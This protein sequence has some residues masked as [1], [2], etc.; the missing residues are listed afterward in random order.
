M[1]QRT[2]DLSERSGQPT[3]ISRVQNNSRN[4]VGMVDAIRTKEVCVGMKRVTLPVIASP[5]L[6]GRH[7]GGELLDA[8][9]RARRQRYWGA[10]GR[11]NGLA[12]VR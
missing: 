9:T 6:E 7:T 5:S 10:S 12:G 1:M 8:S 11:G 4:E 2:A 3:A